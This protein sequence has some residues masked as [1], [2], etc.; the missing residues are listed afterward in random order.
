MEI[1][2]YCENAEADGCDGCAQNFR[3]QFPRPKKNGK[4]FAR[5]T[6]QRNQV[7]LFHLLNYSVV[8]KCLT[9]DIR[10][11]QTWFRN[12]HEGTGSRQQESVKLMRHYPKPWEEGRG[13]WGK[14]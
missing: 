8:E 7:Y 4:I 13:G 10:F 11:H 2:D 12:V 1:L 6:V 5:T 14:L 3:H 9:S